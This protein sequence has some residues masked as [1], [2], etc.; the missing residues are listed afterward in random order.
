MSTE[1]GIG[2]RNEKTGS[3]GIK[4]LCKRQKGICKKQELLIKRSAQ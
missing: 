1:L 2:S 3:Y 4:N